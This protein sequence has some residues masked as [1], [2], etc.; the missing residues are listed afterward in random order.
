M[1]IRHRAGATL[2]LVLAALL[3][4]PGAVLGQRTPDFLFGAP[5]FTIGVRAGY[6]R[7][8]E[9]GDPYDFVRRELTLNRGDFAAATVGVELALRLSEHM[10]VA[11]GVERSKG[12][13]R[14]EFR[15]WVDTNDNPIEQTTNLVRVPL[16]LSTRLYLLPRGRRISEFAW[17][18]YR[19][20]PYVGAGAGV[21][22]YTFEQ[23][24]DFVNAETLNIFSDRISSSGRA[25]LYHVQA[26]ADVSLGRYFV[27]RAELRYDWASA[28]LE[29][30]WDG[31]DPIDL[32]GFRVAVGVTARLSRS[33]R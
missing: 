13:Q 16:S 17:V 5:Q 25:P 23:N 9:T 12:S 30:D 2:V 6:T 31:F 33:A 11:L 20:S 1:R 4:L 28:P 10:D 26:G 18:P 27:G 21:M 7:P 32:G 29:G 22:W 19:W 8:H 24:G 15:D 14:S 3:A